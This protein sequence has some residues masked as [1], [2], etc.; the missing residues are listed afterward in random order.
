MINKKLNMIEQLVVDYQR[1]V[2]GQIKLEDLLV[3]Q[4][5]EIMKFGVEKDNVY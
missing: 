4:Y 1:L 2:D 5:E 3:K